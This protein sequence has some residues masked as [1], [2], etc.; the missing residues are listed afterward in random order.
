MPL[1]AAPVCLTTPY[2]AKPGQK[3]GTLIAE[4]VR[5][6][7]EHRRLLASGGYRPP[8]CPLCDRFLHVLDLR[9][10]KLRD[11][12]DS[13]EEMI[14]RYRCRPCGA[15]WQV[16]PGFI[17]RYLHRTWEA[18]QSALVAAGGLERTGGERRVARKP[19]TLRRWLGRLGTSALVLI[20]ALV[21][22]AA[23]VEGV[24]KDLGVEC[25]RGQW[26]EALAAAGLVEKPRKLA[27]LAC[28]I[29][30]LEPGLRLL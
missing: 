27:H 19:S 24:L 23:P 21:G 15:V 4:Q 16:L 18:V 13:A 10:R 2:S 7:E 29:H 22:A 25:T 5:G 30:R 28:W 12:P 8:G 11:Q 17:A 3:G 20:Q 14:C 26:V 9:P 1:P 6:I